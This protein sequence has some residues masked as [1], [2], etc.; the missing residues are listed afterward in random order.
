M[1]GTILET[2]P[3]EKEPKRTQGLADADQREIIMTALGT[4]ILV[5]AAAGTG[6]TTALVGRIVA[7][8]ATGHAELDRI[9]AVTFTEAAAGELKLRLRTA[10]EKSRLDMTRPAPERHRLRASLPKLEEARVGTVHGFCADL[11]REHPVEAGVDPFF[12]VA[13]EDIAWALFERAF[14]RWFETQLAAPGPAGRRILRRPKREW[15]RSRD[16]GP[17][18]ALRQAAWQLVE[19]RDFP[20]PWRSAG[21]FER[22]QSI[23]EILSEMK[24]LSEWA[25]RADPNDWFGKT[26]IAIAKAVEEFERAE[27]VRA[28]DYD[29]LEAWFS[30]N[31]RQIGRASCRERVFALV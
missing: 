3:Q 15:S 25:P 19:H 24:S 28:R 8:I 17:R 29:G 14:D 1:T 22:D 16:E 18:G 6:K 10:I 20:A 7:A 5:E 13:A 4:N 23:D 9:V 21:A 30:A 31:A 11:L 2:V 12:E 26:L 27:R